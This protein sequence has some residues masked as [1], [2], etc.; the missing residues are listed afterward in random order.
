MTRYTPQWLQNGSYAGSQ[1]RR[2]ISAIW[3]AAASRGC[4]VTVAS[5]MTVN[6]AA[7]AVAVPTQ[8]NT[9]STLCTSDAV[10]AVTLAAAPASGYN[11][12]DLVVC[13]PRGND[14]DG[15]SNTDFLFTTVTGSALASPTVPPAPAGTVALAQIYVPGG[16]AA[17]TAANVVDVRPGGLAIPPAV[18]LLATTTGTDGAAHVA[19]G[20][21]T[22]VD[23]F[24][25]PALTV[26]A[27]RRYR[28]RAMTSSLAETFSSG[29]G[30][31]FIAISRSANQLGDNFSHRT[32]LSSLAL[33]AWAEY[34][35]TVPAGSWTFAARVWCG[36]GVS[37]VTAGTVTVTVEDL[38]S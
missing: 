22:A 20:F 28:V 2:L 14:L 19:T 35:G 25:T 15:G 32:G 6:V 31:G 17:V 33:P 7:G 23:L 21:A 11:R 36:A 4:H 1:D 26:A 16:S 34:V 38:G 9:G 29:N 24:P 3:P 30:F 13:Q 12:Y 10:E 27:N 8:N 18:T 37:S 5:G